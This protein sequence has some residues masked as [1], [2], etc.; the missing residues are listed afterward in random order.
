MDSVVIDT[1]PII[2]PTGAAMLS[3]LLPAAMSMFVIPAMAWFRKVVPVDFPIG[4]PAI[5]FALTFGILWV[6]SLWLAP[7]LTAA[8]IL[9]F[10]LGTDKIMQLA[11]TGHKTVKKIKNGG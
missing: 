4:P 5:T 2:V 10:T 7:E 9:V 6:S 1:L 8:E 11:Y 3:M